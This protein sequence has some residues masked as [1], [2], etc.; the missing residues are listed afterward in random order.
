MA[1][2]LRRAYAEPGADEGYRVSVDR[3]W[4]RGI[5][6]DK[7]EYD[8]WMK[9]IAPSTE[10]RKWFNHRPERW[11]EFRER[12]ERELVDKQELVQRLLHQARRGNV[13]LIY[14]S[15]N[16]EMNQAVALRDYLNKRLR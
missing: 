3:I 12:Y 9:D 1:I 8:E 14:G 5:R 6:K 16:E 7:L 11:D 13:T 10:L 4:P 15:K 2:K